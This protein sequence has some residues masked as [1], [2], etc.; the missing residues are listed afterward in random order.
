MWVLKVKRPIVNPNPG[1]ME[2]LFAYELK[3]FGKNSLVAKEKKSS[4]VPAFLKEILK[5]SPAKVVRNH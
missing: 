5:K 2:H 4:S 3:L 1:F